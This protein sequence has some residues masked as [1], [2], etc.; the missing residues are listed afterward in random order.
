M[1]KRKRLNTFTISSLDHEFAVV[2]MYAQANAI[3][4]I[5]ANYM[6][7]EDLIVQHLDTVVDTSV[8]PEASVHTF[9]VWG[10][11]S[12]DPREF[13]SIFTITNSGDFD[14]WD[15]FGQ[16]RAVAKARAQSRGWQDTEVER[17]NIYRE[18][19]PGEPN[20]TIAHHVFAVYGK[21]GE[22]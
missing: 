7:W 20:H 1:S 9:E 8:E 14:D 22:S 17:I 12:D 15:M 13:L 4:N 16:A 5:Q 18:S 19:K 10:C 2:Q 3:A 6:G 21:R 11:E